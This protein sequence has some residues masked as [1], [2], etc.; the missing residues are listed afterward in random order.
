MQAWIGLVG[1]IAGAVIALSGQYLTRRSEVRERQQTLLLEQCALVTA[2]AEDFR[3]R[4]W[5]ERNQVAEGVVARWDLGAYRLAQARLRIL[6]DETGVLSALQVLSEAGGNLG[7]IW[8]YGYPPRAGQ[9]RS[10]RLGK[11]TGPHSIPLSP[12]APGCCA[13]SREGERRFVRSWKSCIIELAALAAR[14]SKWF[15]VSV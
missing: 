10:R 3:N 14:H 8:R 7:R 13:F 2:L 9:R 4:V 12:P 11:L 5:E 6:C 15:Y 1:V